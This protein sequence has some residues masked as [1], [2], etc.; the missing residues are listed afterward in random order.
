M[1]YGASPLKI[2]IGTFDG[3]VIGALIGLAMRSLNR[4]TTD[5]G[6]HV[7]VGSSFGIA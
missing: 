1:P 6:S 3:M 4:H 7:V 2:F 5:Y